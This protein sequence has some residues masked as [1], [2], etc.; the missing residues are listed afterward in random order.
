VRGSV[1]LNNYCTVYYCRLI[2]KPCLHK[3]AH[4]FVS[5]V[6][7]WNLSASLEIFFSYEA[8]YQYLLNNPVSGPSF[9]IIA[10]LHLSNRNKVVVSVFFL[11]AQL[12]V[13]CCVYLLLLIE[14]GLMHIG[15]TAEMDNSFI[16]CTDI[17]S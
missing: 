16:L 11:C 8:V 9:I 13:E 4:F 14:V 7:L 17:P 10:A 2:Y 15:R 1:K 6:M 3:Q 5:T 12:L